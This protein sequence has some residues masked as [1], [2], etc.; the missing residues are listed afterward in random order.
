MAIQ[1]TEA[2]LVR[3]QDLRE[4]SLILTFYT[5]D[6]GKVSG[7]V[8]GVRGSRAQYGGGALELFAHDEIVFYERKKGDICTI[9]QCDLMEYFNPIRS[10]L[11]RIAYAAYIIELLDSVTSPYDKNE[12]IFRLSLDSLHLLSRE[13]SPRRVARIF[14]IKLLTLVGIMPSLEFCAGCGVEM[15][16]GNIGEHPSFSFSQGGLVCKKC[17]AADRGA[18]PILPGTV[19]FMVDIQSMPFDRA[20]RIKVSAKLGEELEAILKKFLEY[21]IDRRLKTVGFLKQI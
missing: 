13:A 6:F 7:V 11:E 20:A 15:V 1:K 4:T 8:R 18:V 5:K 3:R 16:P 9:S 10:S 12:D 19:K 21:H 14:E 17:R 2:I